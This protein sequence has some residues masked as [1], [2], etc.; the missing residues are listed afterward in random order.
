MAAGLISF[1]ILARLLSKDQYGTMA[2]IT[3]SSS[4]I[5]GIS[6]LGLNRSIVRFY[7]LFKKEGRLPEFIGTLSVSS[8][9]MQF[10]GLFL[11]IGISWGLFTLEI[12][13]FDLFSMLPIAIAVAIFQKFFLLLNTLNRMDSKITTYNIY[14]IARQYTTMFV[15]VISV[16]IYK[17][18]YA[19]YISQLLAIAVI[20]IFIVVQC[21]K[22]YGPFVLNNSSKSII[23]QSLS[24]GFPLAIVV[25]CGVIFNLSDR[26]VIAYCLDAEHV[27]SYSVAFKLCDYF[28]QLVITCI[29]L[30]LIPLIYKFWEQAQIEQ[31]KSTLNKILKYYY[32]AVVPVLGIVLLF[33]EEIIVLIASDKYIDAA[34]YLAFIF[35][36][37]VIDFS[38]PFSAGLHL[39][40]KTLKILLIILTVSLVNIVLNCFMVPA[41]GVQGAAYSTLICG[42]LLIFSFYMV[43]RKEL[44]LDIPF[45]SILKY[46]IFAGFAYE[47]TAIGS[48]AISF[49]SDPLKLGVSSMVYVISYILFLFFFDSDTQQLCLKVIQK[50]KSL[51]GVK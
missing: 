42:F 46:I 49:H 32:M 41:L 12:I 25:L 19:F 22:K 18:L 27:A 13:S 44:T 43:S 30:S 14:S 20:S 9:L 31:I 4:I 7:H 2:L 48:N 38:F 6:S 3:V 17:N 10:V 47:I 37:T 26:Y 21:N 11:S 29:N 8:L 34:P 1:P 5:V 36:G 24:Y 23:K 40:N 35:L 51:E 15:A 50:F 39:K 33:P 45:R 16:L 28:R